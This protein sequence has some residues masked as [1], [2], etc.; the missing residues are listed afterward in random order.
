MFKYLPPS[1][2]MWHIGEQCGK[3][4]YMLM[5]EDSLQ[6][7][8][9]IDMID[10]PTYEYAQFQGKTLQEAETWVEM[11]KTSILSIGG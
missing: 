1:E 2:G 11:N 10:F 3:D 7:Y 9:E 6:T 4:L 8:F 5:E